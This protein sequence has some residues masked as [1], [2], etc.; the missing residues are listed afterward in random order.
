M[1]R[2]YDAR[3]NVVKTVRWATR[4]T[5]TQYTDSAIA[6]A[7]AAVQGT[8]NDEA[9]RFVYDTGDRPRFTIDALGSVSENVYDA[10]GNVIVTTRF[11]RRPTA[12]FTSFTESEVNAAVNALRSDVDNQVIHFAYDANNR[13]RF[14]VDALGSVSESVYDA[15]GNVVVT[16]RFAA[17]PTLGNIILNEGFENGAMS[18]ILGTGC[19]VVSTPTHDGS[20]AV[21]LTGG[22]AYRKA[23]QTVPAIAG[24]STTVSSWLKTDTIPVGAQTRLQLLWLDATST[25]TGTAYYIGKVGGTT[26]WTYYTTTQTAPANAVY[27]QLNLLLDG[28]S[29]GGFAYFDDIRLMVPQYTE[30]TI[31]AAVAP[32][33]ANSNNRATHFAYD[34]QNRLRFT[35]DALGSVSENVYDALGNVVSIE[36][37]AVRPP[38]TQYATSAINAAV[39]SE[40]NNPSNQLQYNMYDAA[41]QVR[42]S[43]QRVSVEAGQ[44]RYQVTKQERNAL[45]QTVSSTSYATAVALSAFSEAAID[46]AV[47]TGDPSKDRVSR[48]V[49]DVAG[50]Q[51]YTLQAV[52]VEAEQRK[53]QVSAQQFD[54]FGRVVGS[55]TYATAVVVNAF[56]KAAID[57]A[58][59]AVAEGTKDRASAVAYDALDRVVYSVR[60]LSPGVHQ[61]SQQEYDALGRVFKTTQYASAV[62]PLA[63]F[64]RATIEA[65][66][67][68]VAGANDRKVQSVYDAVG[69]QRFVLQTNSNARWT[70][71]ESRYDVIGNVVESRR[72]DRYVTEAWMATVDTTNS[73]GINE[74]EMLGELS[75]LGYSD[76]TPSTLVNLQRTRFVY[77]AQNRLRFTIDALGSI[78]E[79]L[80]D[81]V[82]N[83]VTTVRFAARPT[84]TQYTES[85]INV[86][87]NHDDANNQV[88][89]SAYDASGQLRL[90]VHV[91]E[92]NV[93]SGGKHRVTERRYNAF[94]QLVESR[95]Y[96]ELL[97][98]LTAYDELTIAAALVPD[99]VND[100][101]SVMAYD[102]GGRQIYTVRELRVGLDNKHLVTRFVSD[103]LR[104]LVHRIEY[105]SPVTLTQF[106]NASID[107]AVVP[108]FSSDRTTTYVHDAAGRL[109]FEINPDLSFRESVYD[110]L[111][112]V[113]QTRQF[114][115]TL[116]SNVLRTEAEMVALRGNRVVGDGGTRGQVHTYDAAGRLAS[117][118]DALNKS[119]RYEYNT[120]GDRTLWVDKNGDGWTCE[121]DRRGQKTK[122]TAPPV[123]VQLSN[124]TAPT[125]RSLQT[126][127]YY[128]A[129]GSLVKRIE[130][131]QTVDQ[132][133]TEYAYDRLG[134]QIA[135]VQPGWY[136]PATGRVE[137]HSAAGRFQRSLA[138]TYDAL[139]NQVR[140]KLRT[141]INSYQYEHKTYD[142]L[143]RVV[144]DVDALS[145][146]TAFAY[147]AFGEQASVTRYSKSVGTPPPGVDTP[148]TASALASALGNDPLARTMTMRYDNLGR[149]TQTI[150]PTVA[151]YFFSGSFGQ[152]V[153]LDSSITP[154][155]ASGSTT[156]EYNPFGELCHQT[157]QLDSTR[158]QETWRYYDTMGRETRTIVKS[159]DNIASEGSPPRP[160]G[161]HT[162]RSYDAVG[163]LTQVIE[164]AAQ[165]EADN[166]G[167]FLTA[168]PTPDET[169]ADRISSYVYDARN[170]QTDTLR[171]NL[172]YTA[173]EN[174]QYVQVELG[175]GN[176]VKVRHTDYDGL[177][178]V[179]ASTDAMNNVTRSAYNA[180]GQLIQVTEPARLVVKS[181]LSNPDPFLVDSQVLTAPVTD[182]VLNPFGQTVKSTRSPGR[183][184]VAGATLITSTSYDFGGNAISTTD[185]KGNVKNWQYDFSGRLVKETQAISSTLGA[186]HR[187]RDAEPPSLEGPQPHA[188]AALRLRRRGPH[189]RCAGR[190]HERPD[191]GPERPTQSLQRVR[192][193]HRGTN[194][195]G[196]C[197]RCA[198]QLAA[199]HAAAQ[200]L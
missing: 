175:R 63:N 131:A 76:S 31:D 111:N 179:R 16:T 89:H 176:G 160:G 196:C 145:N 183:S 149:K 118:V 96:A 11:A 123:V 1:R 127:L 130:A 58:V 157:V 140:T 83:T 103:A 22:A 14:T 46:A 88:Q 163:N 192:R 34:E 117:T 185:A 15:M 143:G 99:P 113:T 154:V 86:V 61:V 72:Y 133:I 29:T 150:Q 142:N 25:P 27:A 5:L 28:A 51:I 198:E 55:T 80:Y 38:L 8:G 167:N 30:S 24:A 43:V 108:H 95:A 67:N 13:L 112:Q 7:L 81:A 77:D 121:Y 144:Y 200:R 164:Y 92:P 69:R 3:G 115:F 26:E 153:P 122:E 50:H 169:S 193:S 146:V 159:S 110:A 190:V 17:R 37:F 104:Q 70:V 158:A 134:R 53:Y 54:A 161:V 156:F 42:F 75:S 162:A 59:H 166:S 109:R 195:M 114:D 12:G 52:T 148:W 74:Q 9:T 79:N 36:R 48:F 10:L 173:L 119:E 180:L 66:V 33:R 147:N 129:F 82:G 102:A 155:S 174:G 137:A 177:G 170:Q 97:G 135:M 40:R 90:T 168:P 84:L 47:G 191:I 18:W 85:A 151:S 186:R 138:T 120:F 194:R 139:G 45:G 20:G 165:G 128:D 136:D 62:G 87:V 94:G 19:A 60:L 172:S 2:V 23:Q 105:A 56:D 32:L 39:A 199:R 178:R 125:N 171:S 71:S 101:R 100:R 107:A 181:G 188:G 78:T 57:A 65:A 126:R 197:E 184:D 132:R 44:S 4:P 189:D 152:F 68:A 91:M 187:R 35:V 73:P 182:L 49:Y 21:K 116:P 141:G 41:G 124:E 93:G 64:E 6:A 98:H 106:D